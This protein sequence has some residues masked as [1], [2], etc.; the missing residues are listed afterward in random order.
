MSYLSDMIMCDLKPLFPAVVFTDLEQ[1]SQLINGM[2]ETIGQYAFRQK[3]NGISQD[4]AIRTMQ[5]L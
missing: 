4:I 1:R 3:S 5:V 2:V